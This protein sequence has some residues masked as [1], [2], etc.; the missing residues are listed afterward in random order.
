MSTVFERMTTPYPKYNFG[1]P[2]FGS[3]KRSAIS[4]DD[5]SGSPYPV[6]IVG[7]GEKS[8]FVHSKEWDKYEEDIPQYY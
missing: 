7:G 8:S 6:M 5:V 4:R 3:A 1:E 2:R